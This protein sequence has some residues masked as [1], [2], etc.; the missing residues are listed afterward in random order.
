[1]AEQSRRRALALLRR[2]LADPAADFR[3]GQWEAI[4]SLA[5]QRARLLVVQRTGWGKSL[6]YFLT[7]RLLRERGAGPTLLVSP[8]LALMRN[9]IVAAGRLG[10]RAATINSSNREDW[11]V[12]AAQLRSDEV[13]LLLIS[14]ER[15][16]ND[17]FREQLLLPV[18]NRIGFFV[19]DEAH[20]ISDWGHDFRPDYQRITRVLQALP[21]NIPVL[22]TTATANDRVVDDI[23][24]QLGRGL[25]VSRG[26]LMRESLQLQNFRL[27]SQSSRMAWL[28]EQ[29]PRLPGSGI[30]YTL[31]VRDA[32][33]VA[34]WLRS[35]DIAAYAYHADVEAAA[36]EDLERRLLGNRLKALIATTALGMGFDKPD[37]GFVIHFQRPGSVV[38]YYQQVGRAGRAVPQAY[39]ILLSGSEDRE[40]TE[41]FIRTAF[42]SEAHVTE[43]LDALSN[44][45]DGL[46]LVMLERQVNLTRGQIEKVLKSLVV[47]SPAPVTKLGS[48]W[49]TTPVRYVPDQEKVE[50]LTAI[51]QAEQARMA[52]Y[53]RSREC[54]MLFLA[55]ELDDP[56]AVPCGRCAVCR[57][58]P[59]LPAESSGALV[60]EAARFLRRA[61]VPIAPRKQWPGDALA[62][63]GWAGRIPAGLRA[64]TG[65][66]LCLWG[67][68]GWGPLVREGKW[69]AGR[70]SDALVAGAVEMMRERWRPS[71]FPTWVTCIP[72]LQHPELVPGF[73]RLV[74]AELR[75]PF[76][77]A[78]CK[79]RQT[80][81]QK[82]MQNSYQQAHNLAGTFDVTPWTG[83]GE[84]VLL[85]DDV[86]DSGWTFTIVA[87][88]LRQAGSGSVFPLAL[89][90]TAKNE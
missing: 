29:V 32:E 89:A 60:V 64:E 54:L 49:Y 11:E 21:R 58:G 33:R 20:C 37:L 34:G 66:A 57:G 25:Q 12:V 13:D 90:Q 71:P 61:D 78:V 8:L 55:R 41:Y 4:E 27:P 88:L 69:N 74:A 65:R 38:H 47:K 6:V 5:E 30:I 22:A 79:T 9:Q 24:S 36:R 39:G 80:R 77:E 3:G 53:M 75:L 73:A 86:V 56:R 81:P 63:L 59:L 84:P 23:G 44:V 14:P 76:V 40:I 50:R 43:V 31:T 51:R 42:P 87:A 10:V 72:S 28:A 52:D 83:M 26:P 62:A 17:E 1:M 18:A 15:L 35:Q 7:T 82:E 68:D 16:A 85:V 19:V 46:T 70:F 67:D 2:A 48:K 45:E